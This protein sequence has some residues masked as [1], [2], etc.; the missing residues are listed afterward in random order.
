MIKL[1]VFD[2]WNTLIF[3]S[4]DGFDV[5]SHTIPMLK[6]LKAQRI[7]TGLITNSGKLA[8]D[9]IK[10]KTEILRHIDYPIFSFETGL[11][12]PDPRIFKQA[13]RLAKCEPHEALMIGDK[14]ID[15]IAPAKIVGMN[16]MQFTTYENLKSGLRKFA[17][18]LE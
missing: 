10:K 13:L 1:V 7:K 18:D 8:I 12:K 9:E 5:F 6:R 2:L 15:D 17:I 14:M 16:A 11:S 4:G 3:H